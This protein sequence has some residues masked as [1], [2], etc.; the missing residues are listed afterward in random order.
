[1]IEYEDVLTTAPLLAAALWGGMYVVSKWGF[2]V[3]PPVTLSFLRVALG[4]GTLLVL[5]RL[6]KP[7]RSFSWPEWRR[8]IGLGF[9]VTVT[10]VTQ[11]VGTDLTSA[12]QGSLLTVLT[13]VFTF[14][15][16]V[17]LL[18][19]SLTRQNSS[20]WPLLSPAHY[21]FSPDGTI[22][23]L[24]VRG[25]SWE[26]VSCWSLALGG[27]RSLFEVHRSCA[28]ILRLKPQPTRLFPLCR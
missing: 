24:L 28:D 26:S 11:F 20:G 8:F 18:D 16:G 2:A 7:T 22:S 17:A 3:I 21:S 27:L 10:I 4:A 19:E 13:P 25:T 9:W 14:G 5:V 15:L 12:S 6:T 23:G 1:V